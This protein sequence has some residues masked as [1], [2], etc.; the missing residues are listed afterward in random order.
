MFNVITWQQLLA[1]R[2]APQQI[3][4][5]TLVDSAI[6]LCVAAQFGSRV[7]CSCHVTV[8]LENL[9]AKPYCWPNLWV[10]TLILQEGTNGGILIFDFYAVRKIN[11]YFTL[12]VLCWGA[13]TSCA[14]VTCIP[15]VRGVSSLR[16]SGLFW[17]WFRAEEK[18][19]LWDAGADRP[20][21]RI[22]S[23]DLCKT[24]FKK[25]KQVENHK[26]DTELSNY[27][28]SKGKCFYTNMN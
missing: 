3:V 22:W 27:V 10:G 9:L 12:H 1:V 7:T 25:K 4:Q 24:E 11:W 5:V 16:I 2:L 28:F 18:A 13:L 15:E 26:H 14:D 20:R 8:A 17:V 6:S 21:C 19:R 23:I